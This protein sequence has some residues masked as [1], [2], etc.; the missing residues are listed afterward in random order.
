MGI[1]TQ[2]CPVQCLLSRMV[3]VCSTADHSPTASDFGHEIEKAHAVA[4]DL[5]QL[6]GTPCLSCQVEIKEFLNTTKR[7][8][9]PGRR[10]EDRELFGLT[11]WAT[12]LNNMCTEQDTQG[13]CPISDPPRQS[14]PDCVTPMSEHLDGQPRLG[15]QGRQDAMR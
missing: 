2:A 14:T 5:E 6:V 9:R 12:H 11:E 10:P 15:D 4:R 7:I 1:K 3:E 13:I 8:T